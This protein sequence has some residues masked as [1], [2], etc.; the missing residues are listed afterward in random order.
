MHTRRQILSTGLSSVGL[1]TAGRV[2]AAPAPRMRAMWAYETV[3]LLGSTQASDEL[4]K[5]SKSRG[6]TDV[7]LQARFVRKAKNAPFEVENPAGMQA[8][9]RTATAESIRVHALTGDPMHALRANH[10]RVHARVEALAAFNE[11]AGPDARFA[12]LHLDIEP[13]ALPAWKTASDA[14]KCAL[15]T[16]FVEVNVSTAELLHKRAPGVI[17]GTDI[18][19]WLDKV[20]EDGTPVYPVTF[21]GVT[22][23]AAKHLL[24][25]VDHVGIMSY[26]GR[27]EGPNGIIAI[28]KRTLAYADADTVRGRAFIGVKM[29]DIGPQMET[30]FGRTEQEMDAEVR[31]IEAAYGTR[32]GYAGPAY[33]MYEAYRAMPQRE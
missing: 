30:F 27:A 8:L 20:K 18:V 16:Q 17:L 22:K 23:D 3:K 15:L 21:R 24:D 7:F 10:A 25:A 29:A 13:H 4:V 11:E 32:R 2:L 26:R 9:L 31:K 1:A 12:G 33:F 19:F 5:F 6:I 28:V 14:E